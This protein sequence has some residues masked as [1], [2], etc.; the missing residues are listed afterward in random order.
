MKKVGVKNDN[1]FIMWFLENRL[2]YQRSEIEFSI[3]RQNK[4][5]IRIK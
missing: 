4:R 3:L 5:A 2:S 1:E